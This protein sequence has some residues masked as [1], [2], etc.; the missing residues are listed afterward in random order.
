[1]SFQISHIDKD[2]KAR[3]GSLKTDHGVVETPIFMPVGTAG[4][5]KAIHQKELKNDVHAQIILGNTYH[6]YLRPGIDII[7]KAGGL[8]KFNGWDLPIL[9]DSGGYQV[10]SLADRRKMNENGVV[11]QSHITA[12]GQVIENDNGK[13]SYQGKVDNNRKEYRGNGVKPNCRKRHS[14]ITPHIH[15]GVNDRNVRI[16]LLAHH[17]NDIG[18][19][20]PLSVLSHHVRVI[21]ESSFMKLPQVIRDRGVFLSGDKAVL[22]R[23]ENID[24][25]RSLGLDD[26]RGTLNECV[27][28][29]PDL[30][31]VRCQC[32]VRFF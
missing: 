13:L 21:V 7:R 15:H 31:G 12:D 32:R 6:L 30:S 25:M 1:M 19:I 17:R 9:T 3:A 8:H 5:V 4:T 14:R 29:I 20:N 27:K 26:G 16:S 2:T 24:D 10:Y 23:I 28:K 22:G 11:F 18:L